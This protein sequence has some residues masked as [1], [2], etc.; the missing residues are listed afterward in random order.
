MKIRLKNESKNT[1]ISAWWSTTGSYYTTMVLGNMHVDINSSDYKTYTYDL[2]YCAGLASGKSANT[3]T[4]ASF[5][6]YVAQNNGVLPGNNWV[7]QHAY[8]VL[9]LQFHLLGSYSSFYPAACDTRSL[10][11]QGARMEVDYMVFGSSTEQ[12]DGYHSYIES[13]ALAGA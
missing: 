6:A 1:M 2:Q 11:V 9:G 7:G 12:L 8:Q 10:I 13:S 3:T 5:A 4:E